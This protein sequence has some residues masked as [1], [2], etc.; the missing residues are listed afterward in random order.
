MRLPAFTL[1]LF[2]SLCV[3]AVAKDFTQ[4]DLEK[5]VGELDKAIPHNSAYLYPVKCSIVDSPNVNAY[6]TARKEADLQALATIK[7]V[8]GL[9]LDVTHP[10]DIAA[11][12][13]T[14]T[15]GGRGLY[16]L[17]NNA[18]IGS[19]SLLMETPFEEFAA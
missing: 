18:G 3:P 12:V 4:A 6:A 19:A 7:N 17:V 11:A 2:L 8:Q 10:D 14:V 16:A 5:M 15:K 13:E 1:F 9:R